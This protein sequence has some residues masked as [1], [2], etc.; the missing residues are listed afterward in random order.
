MDAIEAWV[1]KTMRSR[2]WAD[3][4]LAVAA[5]LGGLVALGVTCF[6]AF[7]VL[8]L[9][10]FFLPW[11]VPAPGLW[12][13]IGTAV[14]VGLAFVESL[15]SRRRLFEGYADEPSPA[16]VAL[17][18]GLWTVGMGW[19]P[20]RALPLAPATSRN[21]FRAAA[22]IVC[23]GPRLLASALRLVRRVRAASRV[24]RAACAR[25]LRF[26]LEAPGRLSF[27]Q[28][29]ASA[30]DLDLPSV[31]GGLRWLEGVIFLERDPPG[32][33]LSESLREEL[34]KAAGK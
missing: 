34:D 6:A 3:S 20:M 18:A 19:G 17:S 29:K 12:A 32:L 28:L 13:K 5:L 27:R 8:S 10:L 30:P 14:F 26:A 15:R 21:L 16:G 31:L 2:A 33:T 25:I 22:D 4:A 23:V 9:L 11:E 7:F 24:D 1:R